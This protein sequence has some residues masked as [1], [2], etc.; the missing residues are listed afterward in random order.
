MSATYTIVGA[1][2]PTVCQQEI[3]D[4]KKSFL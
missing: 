1:H 3:I 2:S 4:N